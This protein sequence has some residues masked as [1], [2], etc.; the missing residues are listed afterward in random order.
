MVCLLLCVLL[1]LFDL[2]MLFLL[3]DIGMVYLLIIV[4]DV[5][6]ELIVFVGVLLL[7]EWL[8]VRV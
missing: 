4:C 2:C 1:V 6:G 3:D 8:L 7:K 5:W